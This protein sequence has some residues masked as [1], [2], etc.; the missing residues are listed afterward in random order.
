MESDFEAPD[1]PPAGFDAGGVELVSAV[2]VAPSLLDDFVD[3]LEE[4][5]SFL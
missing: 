4:R 3:L 5:L 2:E 1:S